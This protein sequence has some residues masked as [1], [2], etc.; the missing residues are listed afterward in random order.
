MDRRTQSARSLNEF[1][2]IQGT[3]DTVV[4][5]SWGREMS[6]SRVSIRV[7]SLEAVFGMAACCLRRDPAA[8]GLRGMQGGVGYI[9]K[10]GGELSGGRHGWITK[11]NEPQ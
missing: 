2:K 5:A 11:H 4:S 6:D 3:Y 7:E 9:R 10:V 8:R 1:Q